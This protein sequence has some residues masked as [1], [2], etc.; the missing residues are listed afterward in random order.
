MTLRRWGRVALGYAIF[1]SAQI[2]VWALLAPSSFYDNFPGLGRVWVAVD[3]PYNE[4]LIRDVGALNLALCVLLIAAFVRMTRDLVL[5]AGGAILA[6]GVPHAVYHLV[7][8]DGL[9]SSDIAL[10]LGGLVLFALIGGG[11][12]FVARSGELDPA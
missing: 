5:V 6:W 4:H 7:N 10:S 1:V 8:T 9:D 12:I 2:A 3:G 11:L